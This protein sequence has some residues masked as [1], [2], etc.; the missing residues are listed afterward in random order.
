MFI[1]HKN[2]PCRAARRCLKN[3]LMI[4]FA[5]VVACAGIRAES[6]VGT[7]FSSAP[8]P[9]WKLEGQPYG[10]DA[11]NLYEYI[12]GAA[13]F[14]IAFGFIELTGANYAPVSGHNDA[15][16][17]D[18][19]NMGSKLNAFGLFQSRRDRKSVV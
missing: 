3:L 2:N 10:Y 7:I 12:N 15:V 14:F 5:T 6:D 18:V 11:R 16:T 13:E 8:I 17:V 4:L 1:L 19:Y 9:E